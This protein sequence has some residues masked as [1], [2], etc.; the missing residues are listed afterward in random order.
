MRIGQNVPEF[1][2][3]DKF[4]T[5]LNLAPLVRAINYCTKFSS[6]D[7][8]RSD[9]GKTSW[10]SYETAWEFQELD[11]SPQSMSRFRVSPLLPALINQQI[12]STS[13]LIPN[14]RE[15][16]YRQLNRESDFL[17][18]KTIAI[19]LRHMSSSCLGKLK[20]IANQNNHIWDTKIDQLPVQIRNAFAVG[21]ELLVLVNKVKATRG[22]IKGR[23]AHMRAAKRHAD[24]KDRVRLQ[25]L[26]ATAVVMRDYIIYHCNNQQWLLPHVYFLEIYNK[27]NELACLLLYMHFADG[28]S[29]P[30][31]HY[32]I[33]IEFLNHCAKALTKIRRPVSCQDPLMIDLFT[34]NQGFTYMKT[35]EAL[36]VGIM[37][38]REDQEHFGVENRLLLDT[39]WKALS[40][41]KLTDTERV[42]DSE[43]YALLHPLETP[44]ISDLIGIVKVMGHPTIDVVSGLA[45]LDERVHKILA[46]DQPALTQCL[47]V[48]IRDLIL[49]FYKR[50][51]RYPNMKIPLMFGSLRRIVDR[52]ISPLVGAG[53]DV[54]KSVSAVAWS[55][56]VLEKNAEFDM[57][58]R[59]FDLIKDKALGLCRSNVLKQFMLPINHRSKTSVVARRALL[60]YLLTPLFTQDFADY[61]SNYM[62]G[63]DFGDEVLEYLVVKLTAKELELKIKGRYFGASPMEERI[64]RQIQELNTARVMR[65][66]VPEQLLTPGELDAM[67]RLV[68]FKRLV[69]SYPGHTVIHV[70]ADFSSWNN[71][72]RRETVDRSA[73][74]VLDSWF[75]LNCFYQKTML[76]F[77]RMLVY[78]DD[79]DYRISWD[80]Q[81][82]GIEGLNQATWTFLFL[83]G[84]KESL[85]R[86]GYK[87][88]ITVKG[89]DVRMS[90]LIPNDVMATQ[91]F[92]KLRTAIMA[93]MMEKCSKLGWQLNPNESFV[94]LSIVCTSKQYIVNDTWL[95]CV[96]KKIMKCNAIT[97]VVFPTLVDHVS[98]VYSV[99][100]SACAQSTVGLPCYAV[101]A[102]TAGRLISREM[103]GNR[104]TKE[105]LLAL[106]LWPQILGGLG[107]LP[108]QTFFVRGENDMLSC[109]LSLFRMLDQ[110]II[111]SEEDNGFHPEELRRCIR[112][113]LNQKV[114]TEP[115]YR[116]L[117]S[118]PYSLCI[119]HP[120][121]PETILKSSI[122]TALKQHCKHPDVM[123]L[124]ST[125]AQEFD[126]TLT[127][128]LMSTVPCC[129]K[130]ASAIWE[131]SATH[132]ITELI[133]KFLQSQTIVSFLMQSKNPGR[134]ARSGDKPQVL[135]QMIKAHQMQVLYWA[136]V[137]KCR[138]GDEFVLF[139]AVC[140]EWEDHSVCTTRVTHELRE[141]IWK[142]KLIG[143]TYPSLPDQVRLWVPGDPLLDD[144]ET[145]QSDG[146]TFTISIRHKTANPQVY[147][148]SHHY[149]AD[150]S[151]HAWLGSKT[152]SHVHFPDWPTELRSEPAVKLMKLLTIL[153]AGR[154]MNENLKH[155]IR[156]LLSVMTTISPLKIQSLKPVD[157]G[158]SFFHRIT[159]HQYSAFTMPN[160][161]PNIANFV[162]PDSRGCQVTQLTS[163]ALT[164]NYA[165]VRYFTIPLSTWP[166][167]SAQ[168]LPDDYP[169]CI[170]GCY[171]YDQKAAQ[172][173]QYKLCPYCCAHIDDVNIILPSPCHLPVFSLTGV[174][175]LRCTDV[176]DRALKTA[177]AEIVLKQALVPP[178][179]DEIM[180][181]LNCS[182][183]RAIIIL[184]QRVQEYSA[185]LTEIFDEAGLD[186]ASD[187]TVVEEV[188]AGMGISGPKATRPDMAYAQHKNQA[189]TAKAFLVQIFCVFIECVGSISIDEWRFDGSHVQTSFSKRCKPLL[190]SIASANVLHLVIH[191]FNARA[192]EHLKLAEGV[193]VHVPFD[194]IARQMCSGFDLAIGTWLA[195]IPDIIDDYLTFDGSTLEVINKSRSDACSVMQMFVLH[196]LIRALAP[197]I[198]HDWIADV[199]RMS[200][201]FTLTTVP[202]NWDWRT[203]QNSEATTRMVIILWLTSTRWVS[204]PFSQ[205]QFEELIQNGS[206]TTVLYFPEES[207][208]IDPDE[209]IVTAETVSIMNTI[210]R[211]AR[212]ILPTG[213]HMNML[214]HLITDI[215]REHS[216][217]CS[218][219]DPNPV[220][221]VYKSHLNGI[222]WYN[223]RVITNIPTATVMQLVSRAPPLDN[224]DAITVHQLRRLFVRIR[225]K[226]TTSRSVNLVSPPAPDSSSP[227]QMT[228]HTIKLRA[229]LLKLTSI[230]Y[231]PRALGIFS[232][233][234]AYQIGLVHWVR[235]TNIRISRQANLKTV[236]AAGNPSG[237]LTRLLLDKYRSS[238]VF[239]IATDVVCEDGVFRPSF[240]ASTPTIPPELVGEAVEP[241]D[242][243][244]VRIHHGIPGDLTTRFAMGQLIS[245]DEVAAGS[246][247]ATYL[248]MTMI[249]PKNQA[250]VLENTI[251]A[252]QALESLDMV[253]TLLYDCSRI[254][255]HALQRLLTTSITFT[256][257]IAGHTSLHPPLLIIAVIPSEAK[258]FYSLTPALPLALQ[259]LLE[260]KIT[261]AMDLRS[262]QHT[263]SRRL[264]I[265]S[266][267]VSIR[268]RV[269][270]VIP[271]WSNILDLTES[272]LCSV[273][274]HVGEALRNFSNATL[275]TTLRQM[276]ARETSQDAASN[277]MPTLMEAIRIRSL[278]T[279]L[280]FGGVASLQENQRAFITEVYEALL[281]FNLRMAPMDQLIPNNQQQLKRTPCIGMVTVVTSHT[282]VIKYKGLSVDIYEMV[283]KGYCQGFDVYEVVLNALFQRLS[284]RDRI[285]TYLQAALPGITYRRCCEQI[286]GQQY[287]RICDGL[288]DNINHW[289]QHRLYTPQEGGEEASYV[290]E[291]ISP[292]SSPRYEP[293]S[294]VFD[295][296]PPTD[297]PG[298]IEDD[299]E[300]M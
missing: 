117:L 144:L 212:I 39:M 239:H 202:T 203:L 195:Q 242:Q 53:A 119:A 18:K 105:E 87:Y 296:F 210:G 123:D 247:R 125:E 137:V 96:G 234:D 78:Y 283:D 190:Q 182:Q 157:K 107:S 222:N 286:S 10:I 163:H 241:L 209:F 95:P 186:A 52:N 60:R 54:V 100:H 148:K 192:P 153:A 43:L 90:L 120:V 38:L 233:C 68:G 281:G 84:I 284:M 1:S 297:L 128:A 229:L 206:P 30:S 270:S 221:E 126:E 166:L 98:T 24:G 74:V 174:Q 198:W 263:E 168:K 91:G 101:A 238:K 33:G 230:S 267:L 272:C 114:E 293:D 171:D 122:L 83:A 231:P 191:L 19:Q 145:L 103:S 261:V 269:Q 298:G 124:L 12:L 81:L 64:R 294:P 13:R 31:G 8:Y 245:N 50:H 58:D 27:V 76:A 287:E 85:E 133:S 256:V 20:T 228:D 32:S 93:E 225:S 248:D 97:N 140:K 9:I 235:Y 69:P 291:T 226:V 254:N 112:S 167:Q 146:H 219:E 262:E 28:T 164:I 72:F 14:I 116:Q 180:A 249:D 66:Y 37:S 61:I 200:E 51:K 165:A 131:T 280:E 115:N 155:L 214:C 208:S 179:V 75:G 278:S 7:E 175:S 207:I 49:N 70:S 159:T 57:A 55:T 5:C 139:G 92:V 160:Y 243:S 223:K 199:R 279:I 217:M 244:R 6:W 255:L 246:I 11:Y 240:G 176:E 41:E 205:D 211:M 161:R 16:D 56:V 260:A 187:D 111:P 274:V 275:E 35:M 142:K 162:F 237:Y 89:D 257:D 47:G 40:E 154:F 215:C 127:E 218:G 185:G 252:L 80:G 138:V 224:P 129:P 259:N 109:S 118:D 196:S 276:R 181:N 197:H 289:I 201:E 59:Q 227:A 45:Q 251:S 268:Y 102:Y 88:H 295:A 188:T 135:R 82:G 108:L 67:H 184:T 300:R 236:I 110:I 178:T 29:L 183:Q 71:N 170:I 299:A 264:V 86:I 177:I 204:P 147:S 113:I 26:K 4:E 213:H 62:L 285:E 282:L 277:L 232:S 73:G 158:G 23:T 194:E 36:G 169:D 173:G 22:F 99:A 141:R 273:F 132:L 288:R 106:C 79:H 193:G 25:T 266:P 15:A 151:C 143:I 42:E 150:S 265:G 48:M 77:E 136:K 253:L 63:T 21:E 65:D 34:D 271:T 134:F 156:Q 172:L 44:Q 104:L 292:R 94:S 216:R 220:I 290:Y 130:V 189:A 2:Q 3:E 258:N 250:L 121:R 46:I 17:A 152:D 149:I